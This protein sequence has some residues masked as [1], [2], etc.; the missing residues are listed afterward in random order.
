MGNTYFEVLLNARDIHGNRVSTRIEIEYEKT[1][2]AKNY[3]DLFLLRE[4]IPV[5]TEIK[6]FSIAGYDIL[7]CMTRYGYNLPSL[8]SQCVLRNEYIGS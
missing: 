3:V 4:M 5:P 6:H 1:N 7:A 2:L 8:P